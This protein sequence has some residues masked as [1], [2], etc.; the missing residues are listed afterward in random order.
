VTGHDNGAGGNQHDIPC[1]NIRLSDNTFDSGDGHLTSGYSNHG[2]HSRAGQTV[3]AFDGADPAA[4]TAC[5]GAILRAQ[6]NAKNP[7]STIQ[8]YS[9]G[10]RNPFGIRFAPEDSALKGRLFITENGEDERG[11]RPTNNAPDRLQVAEPIGSGPNIYPDWHGWPDRFGYLD[12]TESVFNPVGGP[13]DD[14]CPTTVPDTP[15]EKACLTAHGDIPIR[16]VLAYPPDNGKNH[17]RA[18]LALEP[19]DVAVVG[20]DFAPNSFTGSVVKKGAA[21]VSREGDFG[22]S[23]GNGE[24][25]EGHDVQLV[26]F[27]DAI[28]GKAAPLQVNL[29][30]FAFNCPKA[31]QAHYPDGSPACLS[32][33]ADLASE[34][35]SGDQAFCDLRGAGGGPLHGINRPV[36]LMFGPDGALYVVDYGVVRDFGQSDP[37]CKFVNPADAP[38]VQIPHTGVI[39]KITRAG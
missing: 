10:Y 26:N 31:N 18:P 4:P 22:F 39:W 24:P 25:E 16:H 8:P 35:I 30:R 33:P 2:D 28:V 11:A 36:T 19:A 5:T 12:S 20:P 27:S 34:P 21:L 6:V 38:L 29:E 15:A 3:S 32:N 37:A 13:A 9:W 14:A 17:A 23:P 1:Q 7:A